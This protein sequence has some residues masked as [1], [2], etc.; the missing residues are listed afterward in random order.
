MFIL[1]PETSTNTD[2][3]ILVLICFLI[4]NGI[5]NTATPSL[6]LPSDLILDTL[7]KPAKFRNCSLVIFSHV[8]DSAIISKLK[9]KD[10][11][12]SRSVILLIK[13]RAFI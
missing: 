7:L 13:Q 5:I 1:L 8:S 2:S 3:E 11:K 6:A 9:F 12:N 4:L 10:Y